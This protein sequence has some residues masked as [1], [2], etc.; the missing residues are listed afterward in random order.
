MTVIRSM[1]E[2]SASLGERRRAIFYQLRLPRLVRNLRLIFLSHDEKFHATMSAI[3]KR[4]YSQICLGARV[5]DSFHPPARCLHPRGMTNARF[6]PSPLLRPA[7][8]GFF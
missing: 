2:R 6:R 5:A 7:I 8:S 3:L 1:T 4:I